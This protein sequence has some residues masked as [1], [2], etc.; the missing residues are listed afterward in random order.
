MGFPVKCRLA[1]V[2]M[3]HPSISEV[4]GVPVFLPQAEK[5]ISRTNQFDPGR[6]LFL[7]TIRLVNCPRCWSR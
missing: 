3:D 7:V 6:D 2:D 4:E 1:H 5:P